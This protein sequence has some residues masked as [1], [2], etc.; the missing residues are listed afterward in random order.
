MNTEDCGPNL[1]IAM[2]ADGLC[3]AKVIAASPDEAAVVANQRDGLGLK[4]KDMKYIC[5]E[6]MPNES[7]S[8]HLR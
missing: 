7:P 6:G 4:A 3:V 8:H 5:K 1:Y 2:N